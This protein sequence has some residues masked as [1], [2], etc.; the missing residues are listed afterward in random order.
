VNI[1]KEGGYVTSDGDIYCVHESINL[2]LPR[3]MKDS[4]FLVDYKNSREVQQSIKEG[5]LT[6]FGRLESS[7]NNN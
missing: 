6:H 1:T 3:S 2:F 4:H 5:K 7:V